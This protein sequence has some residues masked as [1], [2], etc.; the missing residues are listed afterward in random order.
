MRSFHPQKS[1][2]FPISL[3][4]WFFFFYAFWLFWKHSY[5]N[6][7][8][9][10]HPL[11]YCNE[12]IYPVCINLLMDKQFLYS[13]SVHVWGSHQFDLIIIPWNQSADTRRWRDSTRCSSGEGALME[14]GLV[15]L[16]GLIRWPV[17]SFMFASQFFLFLPGHLPPMYPC[18]QQGVKSRNVAD[19]SQFF[20]DRSVILLEF[21]HYHEI[22]TPY[23]FGTSPY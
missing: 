5:D 11:Y 9:K 21:V 2:H 16:L 20:P 23:P 1:V 15:H 12:L 18:L 8:R 3:S 13:V 14:A 17:H 10:L 4:V 7:I 6:T 22:L 19:P